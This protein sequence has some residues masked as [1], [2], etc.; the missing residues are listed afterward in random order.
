MRL[1]LPQLKLIERVG[2]EVNLIS[3]LFKFF[4]ITGIAFLVFFLTA[5]TYTPEKFS[6]NSGTIPKM[7]ATNPP[8]P[9]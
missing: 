4:L 5:R 7:L 8:Q 9:Y 2:T 1:F 3:V 6:E